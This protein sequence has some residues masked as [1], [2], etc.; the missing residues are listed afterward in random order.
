[1]VRPLISEHQSG[2]ASEND[3]SADQNY[4]KPWLWRAVTIGITGVGVLGLIGMEAFAPEPEIAPPPDRSIPV[5]TTPIQWRTGTIPVTG[6]GHVEA[7]QTVQLKPQVS[8]DITYVSSALETGGH[9]DKGQRLVS[10]NTESLNARRNELEARRTSAKADLAL[11]ETQAERS[12]SLL[13]RRAVAQDEV[14]QREAAVEAAQARVAE[15]EASLSNV[16][17]D[18]R[19]STI[20]APFNGRVRSESI[21]VGDVVSAGV[22]FAEIYASDVFEI[23]VP[24]NLNDAALLDQLFAP[25]ALDG[26][27]VV[28][29]SFGGTRFRWDGRIHRVEPGIDEIARTINLVV[30]VDAP[31]QSG[32]PVDQTSVDAPPLLLGMYTSVTMQSRHLD[33]FVKLPRE[34]LRADNTV[35]YVA[36]DAGGKGIVESTEARVLKTERE[37]VYVYL[38]IPAERD[39][40]IIGLTPSR[41]VP[42]S[43]V[44]TSDAQ[45]AP[46]SDEKTTT[47]FDG[48]EQ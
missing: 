2:L 13:A 5:M 21:S 42:G 26:I 17:V 47:V 7:F 10:I 15:L 38:D 28:E 8:G 11:I 39:V 4:R 35:W 24:L 16:D 20:R 37:V 32:I 41:V 25:G 46:P 22:S 44:M 6:H 34:A 43:E 36:A 12:R 48:V 45:I 18:L 3:E 27:A 31:E 19:R 23:P 14:D 30:R 9:F 40:Q 33:E 1:M 29:T